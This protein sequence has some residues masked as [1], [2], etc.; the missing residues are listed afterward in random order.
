MTSPKKIFHQAPADRFTLLNPQKL[1]THFHKVP[2]YITTLSSKY[3][4]I[5]SDYFLRHYR[6]NIDLCNVII[7]ERFDQKPECM[8]SSNNGNLGFTIERT[9]LSEVLECYYGGTT[10]GSQDSSPVSSSE[11]R[12]R[13]RLALDITAIVIRMLLGDEAPDDLQPQ[14]NAYMEITWEYMVE[15]QYL[16][17][18]LGTTSSIFLHV[19]NVVVDELTRRLCDQAAVSATICPFSRIK[20]LPVRLDCVLV[21]L[22][23][24]LYRVLALKTGDILMVRLLERCEVQI[25]QQKLF[26]GALC[27]DDGSLFLTSIHSV[28]NS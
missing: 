23:M 20:N 4:K 14:V 27:E 7:H 5:F 3:P 15:F 2:H 9:L 6:L 25:N 16:S 11:D 22:Q 13:D 1:G 12:M 19:D 18:A 26:R 10:M 8:L 17:A 21:S 24:P 28:K